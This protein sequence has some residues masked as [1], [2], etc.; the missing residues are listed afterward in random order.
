[1]SFAVLLMQDLCVVPMLLLLGTLTTN[2]EGNVAMNAGL[3]LLQAL[4]A[5]AFIVVT[6]RYVLTPLL[7]LVA[8]SRSPELFM[9]TVLFIAIGTSALAAAAGLSMSLGAFIAGITLAETE[10]RRA[11]EA[12][13]EPF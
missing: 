7:R 6:G 8:N 5:V 3:A 12:I 9:A 2:D 11:I 13:I 1:M 4:A 10:F